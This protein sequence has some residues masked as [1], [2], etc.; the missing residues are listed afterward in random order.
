M[1]EHVTSMRVYLAVF[2]GLLTF[3][4]LTVWVAYLDLGAFNN[5]AAMGIAVIK[6]VL[7]VLFFMHVA[8]A[9]RLSKLVVVS[10]FLWLLLLFG[11]TLADYFTRGF[12]DNQKPV[13]GIEP[14]PGVE[15]PAE[16]L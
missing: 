8:H 9:S 3:T 11:L 15:A 10:G 14:P 13:D 6:A 2:L 12:L 4:A 7:V 16:E 1:A 5:A